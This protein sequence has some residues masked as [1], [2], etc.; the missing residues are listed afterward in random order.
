MFMQ[1]RRRGP[2]LALAMAFIAV[3]A[4]VAGT[5][6]AHASSQTA[7]VLVKDI[8]TVPN[9][10][11]PGAGWSSPS[12]L[13]NVGGTLFFVAHDGVRGFE[14][15]KSDG[16]EEGT[17]L[18]KDI[19]PDP[20]PFFVPIPEELTALGGTL[21]FTADDG[22]NGRELWKS[23]G[24]AQGTT[25]VKDMWPGSGG[26]GPEELT[27][28]GGTLFLSAA[29]PVSLRELWKSDGTE[30]GT[31]L[32]KDIHLVDSSYPTDLADV[33]GTLFFSAVDDVRG[34]ELWKSDGTLLGTTLVK[35]INPDVLVG[36]HPSGLTNV[37]GTLFF[38]ANDRP[39]GADDGIGRELW[40]SD[41]T[42][43]G[44]TLVKDVFPGPGS[45]WS[46][47]LT[48][49]GGTLFFRA[50]GPE[51]SQTGF[52]QLWKSD[53]TAAG[54][55]QVKGVD[56]EQGFSE[57]TD[58]GGTLFFRAIEDGVSGSELWKSDGTKEGTTLVTD[59]NPGPDGSAPSGL[60]DVGGTLFF[61]AIDGPFETG[62][63]LWKTVE[64]QPPSCAAVTASPS[65]IKPSRDQWQRIA[66]SG[67][68]DPDGSP[69][70]YHIDNVTQ[71]EP[72][73]SEGLGDETF[74]D[75]QLTETGAN[76]NELLVRA[77]SNPRGNGRV[78]RIAYTVFDSLG[79]SCSRTAGV[80][81][82]TGATV[83]VPRKKDGNAVDDGDQNSWDSF[84]GESVAGP[85]P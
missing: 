47:E 59:I 17:T 70:S 29:D 74:P 21:F 31:T 36:S 37:G 72:V 34:T 15:W 77:E 52:E 79:A 54:T 41:G 61:A 56:L 27:N 16:T 13:T 55:V 78:Y 2:L 18:V 48:D 7:A 39:I 40:K 63:E 51:T 44:T 82:D 38:R 46:F 22:V 64:N 71:D 35:D 75:A 83:S 33:G 45:S 28:V 66:L 20:Q 65:V 30:V 85:L 12:G 10:F 53:G 57:L 32:V 5:P 76:S 81:G 9:P 23:D 49:V 68:N 24:T 84:T 4:A 14:L 43:E 80:Q 8:N 62:R 1:S 69:V 73:S 25:L 6:T 11:P 67:A 3:L 19:Y 58:V 50:V 26:S 60:T 42:E